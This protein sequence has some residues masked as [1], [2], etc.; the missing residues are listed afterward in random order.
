MIEL[1]VIVITSI[2]YI[3][4]L[5]YPYTSCLVCVISTNSIESP[6][7]LRK[8]KSTGGWGTNI[9]AVGIYLKVLS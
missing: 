7:G 6:A 8:V 3:N 5:A 9:H 4:L 1:F 2:S